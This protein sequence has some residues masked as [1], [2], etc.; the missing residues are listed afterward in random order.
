MIY[1]GQHRKLKIEQRY[2]ANRQQMNKQ[3][4][5]NKAKKKT[6]NKKERKQTGMNDIYIACNLILYIYTVILCAFHAILNNISI[7]EAISLS[8]NVDVCN[9]N[10]RSKLPA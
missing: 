9:R 6:N 8:D 1:K 5:K 4:N 7:I 10:T 3:T 2:K